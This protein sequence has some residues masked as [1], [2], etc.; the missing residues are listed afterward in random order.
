MQNHP[1]LL[2]EFPHSQPI[3]RFCLEVTDLPLSLGILYVSKSIVR[4]TWCSNCKIQKPFA[5]AYKSH[6]RNWILVVEAIETS[7]FWAYVNI[8]LRHFNV[9]IIKVCNNF[10]YSMVKRLNGYCFSY[11]KQI[12]N[13]CK[14]SP[15]AV[16]L[17]KGV[18][19]NMQQIYRRTPM[20]K[21][22]FS[23]VALQLYW[24]HTS[25]WVFS[26]IFAAYFQN[27]LS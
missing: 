27:T 8:K 21:C 20:Q 3:W 25:A 23:K 2:I 19:K 24:N 13:N 17:G 18:L 5:I 9:I 1:H 6:S 4:A 22:D 26:R 10:F 16:F 15:P 14:S 12:T 11:T 7:T